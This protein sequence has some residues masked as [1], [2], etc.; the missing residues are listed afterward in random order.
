MV[1]NCRY[2]VKKSLL[3][4]VNYGRELRIGFEIRKKGKHVKAEEFVKE[5]K[6]IYKEEK[7]VLNKS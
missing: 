3:F 6:E 4:K 2:T 7:A 1:S 5:M